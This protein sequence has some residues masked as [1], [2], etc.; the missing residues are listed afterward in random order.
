MA[1][2]IAALLIALLTTAVVTPVIRDW[3]LSRGVVDAPGGRRV[4]VNVTPRLGGLAIVCGVFVALSVLAFQGTEVSRLFL[5]NERQVWG[6]VAG[7]VVVATVGGVDDLR[8]LGPWPKLAAQT[9]AAVIAYFAGY[10]IDAVD[11]PVLGTLEFGMLALPITVAWFLGIINALNL[12]DGLDGLA[13]GI[14][15]CAATTNGIIAH[16]NGAHVVAFLSAALAG[17]LIGFLRYNFNPAS[18]FMGDAGSMFL[19]FVLAATALGG[20]T[21][22]SS[23]AVAI[24]APLVALGVPIFDTMLAMLRRTLGKQPIFGADRGHVHH[25]LL[26]LGLT[27]RRAVLFL[28]GTS[29]LLSCAAVAIAFGRN[30]AVGS[31]IAVVFVVLGWLARA[32]RLGHLAGSEPP[33]APA[34]E[35]FEE[36]LA[37]VSATSRVSRPHG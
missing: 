31:G 6:L 36:E 9:V 8:S 28:Y 3:A 24:L 21:I 35:V 11:L 18:I 25:K 7:G 22:K 23:T 33:P 32:V 14:A 10:R 37:R 1:S 2:A 27:H 4:H 34:L 13:A 29:V 26:D 15:L 30:W 19:G 12:I 17:S 5:A 20:A 16:Y